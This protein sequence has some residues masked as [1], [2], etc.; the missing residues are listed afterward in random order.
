[1]TRIFIIERSNQQYRAA[2]T[3]LQA[4]QDGRYMYCKPGL[5]QNDTIISKAY[6]RNSKVFP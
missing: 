6:G 5:E 1:M 3:R 2:F 4:K